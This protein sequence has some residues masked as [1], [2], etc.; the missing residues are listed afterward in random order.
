MNDSTEKSL[1]EFPCEFPIKIMGHARDDCGSRVVGLVRQHVPDL[2]EAAI[3][4]RPSKQGKYLAVTVT[5][6]ATSR[7]QLDA[8]YYALTACEH[9]LMAL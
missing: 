1:L 2:G 3:R 8:I 7:E 9:V 4:S 6:N 5:V